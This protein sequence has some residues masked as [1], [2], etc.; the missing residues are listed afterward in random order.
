M[1]TK[2]VCKAILQLRHL[3]NQGGHAGPPLQHH[4]SSVWA[5]TQVRP[6]N[7]T[8][9]PY[10][11]TRRSAPTTPLFIR[12]GGHAGPPLQH[13]CSSVWAD[14]Q[15]RPYNTTVHPYGRTRRSAPTTPLFIRNG[16]TRRSAHTTPL[17]IR[18]GGPVCPPCLVTE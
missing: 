10:G 13:H 7:T 3:C 9:Y 1:N 4:C 6:Y 8:V 17:F 14:T 12:M 18:R 5:D 2:R 11:R 16:R 15:V